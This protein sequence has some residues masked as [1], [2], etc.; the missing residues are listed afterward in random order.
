M[1]AVV[2]AVLPLVLLALAVQG[3]AE[4]VLL[5]ETALAPRSIQAAAVVELT[6]THQ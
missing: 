2:A 6:A 3:V 4:T 5:L 1:R